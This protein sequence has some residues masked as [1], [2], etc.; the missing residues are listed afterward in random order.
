[1]GKDLCKVPDDRG[2]TL[3]ATDPPI[4]KHPESVSVAAGDTAKFIVK[5]SSD[6]LS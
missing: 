6:K 4:T 2:F 3:T 5:T 1:M